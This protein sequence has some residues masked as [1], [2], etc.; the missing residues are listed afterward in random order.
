MYCTTP[1]PLYPTARVPHIWLAVLLICCLVVPLALS[2]AL[3]DQQAWWLPPLPGQR[4]RRVWRRRR[5]RPPFHRR[6]GPAFRY[7]AHSWPRPLCEVL[8]LYAL[9][10]WSGLGR[11]YPRSRLVLVGPV[12]AWLL[13]SLLWV[14]PR[15]ATSRLYRAARRLV[16]ALCQGT[17]WTLIAIAIRS[18]APAHR[19]SPSPV[20]GR[21]LFIGGCVK[22]AEGTWVYGEITA[23]GTWRLVLG[24]EYIF[25]YQPRNEFE[26]RVLLMMFRHFRTPHSTPQRPLVRQEWLAEWFETY[27]EHISRWQRYVREGGLEKLNGQHERWV[28]TPE[29]CAAILDIWV[30]NFWLSAGQVRQR[31][32]AAGHIAALDDVSELSIH[33]AAEATGFAQVRRLLRRM[34]V[35]TEDGPQWR[36]EV[37]IERLFELNEELMA[38]LQAGQG[39]TP[40]LTLEAESLRQA[41]NAPVLTPKEHFS[42]ARQLQPILFSFGQEEDGDDGSCPTD[43][44]PAPLQEGSPASKVERMVCGVIV[45]MHFRTTYRRAATAVGVSHVTLWRWAMAV[46][47]CALPVAALFGVVRSSGV[48]G[49]DEKWVLV[50]K[51]NKPAGQH[52]R[53]MYV[54]LAVDVFTYDLLHIEIYPYNGKTSARA[55]LQALKAKGYQPRVI[56]T[57]MN[58]DYTQPICAV[59]PAAVHHECVFHALQWAQR[60][61]KEVYGPD[62]AQT[63]PEAEAL[64]Q[65]VYRIFKAKT[66]R[67]VAKRYREVMALQDQY[68][69]ANPQAARLFHFLEGHYPKLVNA[70]ENPL[71]PLT[72]NTVELVIRRFDQH[73]QNMCGFDSIE[74]ARTY[75][76]LFEVFYRLT[77]FAADNRPVKGRELDIRGRCPLELAGYDISQ[78]PL[79]HLLRGQ[80]LGWPPETLQEVTQ[81]V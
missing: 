51:N 24:G 37:L 56:V 78:I 15:L 39:L 30:P 10:V 49:M 61:V 12:G 3:A 26:K 19:P 46:G 14:E 77:P 57:D 7:L 38:R 16:E 4:G 35:F 22:F 41:L 75:L 33:Q 47:R 44:A 36:D 21:T 25:E 81:N 23:D 79:A 54:Y 13:T 60:L 8:L 29:M 67:T 70:V 74:T 62:Y 55:F 5:V 66:K 42:L 32:L 11:S 18:R 76:H 73:Y 17:T 68:V 34:F 28:L 20:P 63:H 72:N 1:P 58:R 48:V 71:I 40:H 64:K 80:I 27:Q 45:Y 53:W 6:V 65:K 69:A 50:P 9:L 59:F 2:P 52:K 43:D 31:L